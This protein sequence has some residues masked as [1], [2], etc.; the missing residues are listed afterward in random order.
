M[1]EWVKTLSIYEQILWVI[2]ILFTVIFFYQLISTVVKKTPGKNRYSIFGFFFT[3]K[4]I[5]AFL[6]MFGW[7]SIASLYQGF[8]IVTSL[9]IGIFG[10]IILMAVMSV[11]F[12]FVQKIKE[13]TRPEIPKDINSI[14]EVISLIGKKRSKLGKIKINID[15]AQRI[16]DAMT[17]FE[18][19]LIE[20]TKI[21][22]ESVTSTGIFII[23]PLQ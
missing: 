9:I 1:L 2:A 18:H 7:V 14:G 4:N 17:D 16:M 5:S 12:Y 6:S 10:G 11:L 8:N 15:G 19:D 3:F 23:K 13:T 21:R 22:V 20:G